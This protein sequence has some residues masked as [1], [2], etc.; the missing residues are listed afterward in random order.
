MSKTIDV[1]GKDYSFDFDFHASD[2][3][4]LTANLIKKSGKVKRVYKSRM[5]MYT[6]YEALVQVACELWDAPEMGEIICDRLGYPIMT[7]EDAEC[8]SCSYIGHYEEMHEN[9][10]AYRC[11]D[12]EEMEEAK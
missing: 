8:D 6:P 7:D 12:C 2:G 10:G 3:F 5:I 9:D 1:Q 4:T 11:N